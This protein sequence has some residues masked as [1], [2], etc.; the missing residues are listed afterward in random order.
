[1]KYDIKSTRNYNI[2]Y[3]TDKKVQIWEEVDTKYMNQHI[4]IS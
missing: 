2:C 3:A 1:M 4:H